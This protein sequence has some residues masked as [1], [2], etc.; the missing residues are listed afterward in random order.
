MQSSAIPVSELI[1]HWFN[2]KAHINPLKFGL[3]SLQNGWSSW[4][5]THSRQRSRND[6]MHPSGGP[7]AMEKTFSLEAIKSAIS[8]LISR[9]EQTP[10][11]V[12]ASPILTLEA[13][14]TD[15]ASLRRP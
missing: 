1:R 11:L 7:P 6:L 13:R 4:I 3:S 2:F 10:K 14:A 12:K 5:G 8:R 9:S 15:L